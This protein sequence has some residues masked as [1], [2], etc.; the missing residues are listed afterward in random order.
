M[1]SLGDQ[2]R[3]ERQRLGLSLLDVT[4][5]TCINPRI[6]AAIEANQVEVLPTGLLARSFVRQYARVVG[7]D[8]D[9]C[10]A[11]LQEQLASVAKT[12]PAVRPTPPV[13]RVPRVPRLKIT[14][15]QV[16]SRSALPAIALLVMMLIGWGQMDSRWRK[17]SRTPVRTTHTRVAQKQ[18]PIPTT[19]E[20]GIALDHTSDVLADDPGTEKAAT[21]TTVRAALTAKEPVWVSIKADGVVTFT[22]MIDVQQ[23]RESD[24]SSELTIL[25]GNAGGLDVS[26][27]GKSIGPVGSRG[28]VRLLQLT[29]QGP[30]FL[31]RIPDPSPASLI[32][33]RPPTHSY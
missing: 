10:L 22:G 6:L 7:V 12:S 23:T 24:A 9:Q 3:G 5:E 27:N 20:Y 32:G 19:P 1:E 30:R 28:Q 13:R 18:T 25:I 11:A 8:E 31:P 2:L 17:E 26:L 29:A 16:Q 15:V 4:A 21:A 33:S 14:R